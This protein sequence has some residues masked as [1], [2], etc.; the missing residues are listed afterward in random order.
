MLISQIGDNKHIHY[1]DDT[2]FVHYMND[3]LPISFNHYF[4]LSLN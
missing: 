1:T 2:K 4:V 3:D